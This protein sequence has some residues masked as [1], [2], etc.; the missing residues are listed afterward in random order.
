MWQ[1]MREIRGRD[2]SISGL[3]L[4]LIL[5]ESKNKVKKKNKRCVHM[6]MSKHL[7]VHNLLSACERACVNM[8]NWFYANLKDKRMSAWAAGIGWMCLDHDRI[9]QLESSCGVHSTI[10]QRRM[11]I[12]ALGLWRSLLHPARYGLLRAVRRTSSR[13]DVECCTTCSLRRRRTFGRIT[14]KRCQGS[15]FGRPALFGLLMEGMLLR[16]EGK[17][18]RTCQQ[19]WF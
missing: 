14:A 8:L 13:C 6:C 18:E 7:D 5:I 11:A 19:V 15:C 4:S 10:R 2:R 16:D 17:V 9:Q 12:G 1:D 3:F